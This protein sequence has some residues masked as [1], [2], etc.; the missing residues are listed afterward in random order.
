MRL[1]QREL[2]TALDA[3]RNY[4]MGASFDWQLITKGIAPISTGCGLIYELANPIDRPNES[5]S[6]ADMRQ[7]NISEPHYHANGETEIYIVLEGSGVVIVGDDEQEVSRGSVVTTPPDTAHYT[8]NNGGLV[9]AVI[10]TPPFDAN[11]YIA[12]NE[13]NPSVKF[14]VERYK[15]YANR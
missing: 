14:D 2:K 10:N 4:L 13:S 3:W 6:I 5:F 7:L 8:L 12:L 11:N 1:K 9:L 15:R